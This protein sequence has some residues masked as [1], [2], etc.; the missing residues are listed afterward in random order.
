MN[1]LKIGLKNKLTVLL[2]VVIV[3]PIACISIFNY[4]YE[5]KA[6]TLVA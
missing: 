1:S 2:V 4:R 6:I 5:K 3:T